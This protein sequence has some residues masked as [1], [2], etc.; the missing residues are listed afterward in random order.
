MLSATIEGIGFWTQGLPSW[1]AASAFARG[2]ELLDT[3]TR[4][5][6]QLLAANERRRAPDTVAVSLE[7][8]LAACHAAG[9]DPASLP[10]IFTST[11]GDLAISDYMCTTLASDPSAISPTKFHNSVHNAAAGYWTIGAGAMTPATAISASLG[12]FA[13]G[14]LEALVQRVAGMDAVLLAG[15]DARSVGPLGR[16]A[17]SHGLLGAALV[18]GTPGQA[19][20]PQLHAQLD[21]GTPSPGDGALARHIARNAMAPMLP[22]FDLLAGGGDS[23]AL[24]AGPGRVLRVEIQ[25]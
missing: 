8:A 1:E 13:Q 3:P 15:Y 22:L 5:A 20:K 17:P 14:L 21:D 10:S 19:G 12:S 25:R 7:S 6:P 23:V 24:Y 18:L 16:V 2:G 4:P 9:R 11:Y